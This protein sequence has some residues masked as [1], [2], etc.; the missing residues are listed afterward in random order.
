MKFAHVINPVKV[1]NDSDLFVAQPVTFRALIAAQNF[2]RTN[3]QVEFLSIAFEE[4]SI[5]LPE[6]IRKLPP[7]KRSVIDIREFS[8]KR[9]LPLI[10]DILDS[11]F[12]NSDAEY[13]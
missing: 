12:H 2:V 10:K 5:E 9:K 8:K 3:F 1:S 6:Q 13:L 4:D 7:L 11:A